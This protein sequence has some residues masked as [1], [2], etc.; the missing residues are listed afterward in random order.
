MASSPPPAAK[1]RQPAL[2]LARAR[3]FRAL[4]VFV[5]LH[6]AINAACLPPAYW[7]FSSRDGASTGFLGGPLVGTLSKVPLPGFVPFTGASAVRLPR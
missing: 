7:F 1:A 2:A 4:G 6:L 3:P 5:A